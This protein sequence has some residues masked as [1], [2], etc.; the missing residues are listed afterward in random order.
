MLWNTAAEKRTLQAYLSGFFLS[1]SVLQRSRW[2]H[3]PWHPTAGRSTQ[4]SDS[5][6]AVLRLGLILQDGCSGA[7][8]RDAEWGK[9]S[10]GQTRVRR[11]GALS[12]KL[13]LT[14]ASS[15]LPVKTPDCTGVRVQTAAAMPSTSWSAV[16][17]LTT[18]YVEMRHL[19]KTHTFSAREGRIQPSNTTPGY[20][21]VTY[22]VWK[23]QLVPY[24]LI[25]SHRWSRHLE[26]S[27]HPSIWGRHCGPAVPVPDSQ[28]QQN[29]LLQKCG[30]SLDLRR[31]FS[32][33][34][35]ENDPRECD[36]GGRGLIQVCVPGRDNRESRELVVREATGRSVAEIKPWPVS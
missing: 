35:G 20:T 13:C 31:R 27:R 5:H 3:W 9:E 8:L 19:G 25:T 24:L 21:F 23:N 14:R 30:R 2:P 7:S 33:T 1:I 10:C 18:H 28:P 12:A 15:R 6:S 36:T 11:W 22:N 17:L 26:D 29:N 4:D 32:G 16:S 34:G